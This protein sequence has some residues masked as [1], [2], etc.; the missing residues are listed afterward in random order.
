MPPKRASPSSSA[1]SAAEQAKTSNEAATTTT[2][3]NT[4]S[5]SD[6]DVPKSKRWAA[7]SG[8]GNADYRYRVQMK[9]PE[10]AYSFI[11]ICRLPGYDDDEDDE[12]ESNAS[13]EKEPCDGGVTCLCDKPVAEHPE[14][15]LVISK[16]GNCKY[17]TQRA[18]LLLRCPDMF[19]MYVTND[20]E[21]YGVM[22]VVENLVL[23]WVEAGNKKNWKEQWVIVEA[24]A[25]MWAGD[26]LK[27]MQMYVPNL[28]FVMLFN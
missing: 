22:E 10:V 28:I 25:M 1:S 21:A 6:A 5:L 12:D 20:F 7:V 2:N 11:C 15:A 27:P 18:L 24:M 9:D 3:T 16:A 19:D 23:D 8:S 26:S 4:V 17:F 13:S 14:H